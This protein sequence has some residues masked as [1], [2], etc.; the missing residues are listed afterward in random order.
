[1]R[2]SLFLY[3]LGFLLVL[4]GAG[5][6]ALSW[7]KPNRALA[8]KSEQREEAELRAE[9]RKLRLGAGIIAGVGVVL[10]LIS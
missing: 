2:R 7:R 3:G 9:A 8:T 5:L 1:M 10:I 4:M 6:F